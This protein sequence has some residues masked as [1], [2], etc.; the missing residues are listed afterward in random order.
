MTKSIFSLITIWLFVIAGSFFWNLNHNERQQEDLALQT[1]RSFFRQ[2]VF[3][4][5]WNARLKGVYTPS[6]KT[7]NPILI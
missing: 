5:L 1:A 2:I 4:R 6:Q 7:P 3:T